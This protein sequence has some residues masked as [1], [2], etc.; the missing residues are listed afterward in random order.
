[1]VLIENRS[2]FDIYF[3]K[4]KETFIVVDDIENQKFYFNSLC[5]ARE[6][7]DECLC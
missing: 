2:G 1:M 7:V 4:K 3:D 5:S 6:F